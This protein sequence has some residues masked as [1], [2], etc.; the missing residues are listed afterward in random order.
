MR[1]YF[2]ALVDD[3]S[4]CNPSYIFEHYFFS[5]ALAKEYLFLKIGNYASTIKIRRRD[6]TDSGYESRE[7]G[8]WIIKEIDVRE[9]I[10]EYLR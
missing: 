1:I 5:L 4:E 6:I 8:E 3:Y 2:A 10:P 9:T 7:A